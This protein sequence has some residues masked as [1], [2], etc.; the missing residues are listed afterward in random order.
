MV[1]DT[2]F[3]PKVIPARCEYHTSHL[4]NSAVMLSAAKRSRRIPWRN[5]QKAPR[6]PSTSL[7]MT[8]L[9]FIYEMGSRTYPNTARGNC[10]EGAAAR[11]RRRPRRRNRR[12]FGLWDRL[13]PF[14]ANASQKNDERCDTLLAW[15]CP[16]V[17]PLPSPLVAALPPLPDVAAPAP[18][19]R[20]GRATA[21]P[22]GIPPATPIV[23]RHAGISSPAQKAGR[24]RRNLPPGLPRITT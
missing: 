22:P 10:G 17:A 7:G 12:E 15:R 21:V 19:D 14:P 3:V 4:I 9:H 5:L 20:V 1:V 13:W 6:D 24:L 2:S 18:L 11:W 8:C 16:S 23:L